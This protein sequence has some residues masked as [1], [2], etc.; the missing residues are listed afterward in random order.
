MQVRVTQPSI[1]VS[2]VSH[3]HGELVLQ[4]LHALSASVR[5]VQVSLRVWLT[6][7]LPEPALQ[8]AVQECDWPFELTQI[9]NPHPLGFGANHN[10]AYALSRAVEG[11]S[12]WF[13]VMNPDIFWPHDGTAFW[14]SL[15]I[16]WSSDVGLVCPAQTDQ[17]GRRQDF[18]RGLMT[19]WGMVWRVLRRLL[20]A[21]PSG[22][23]DSVDQADWINGACM[24]WRA[25]AFAAV[26]GFD[27]RYFMYCEDTDICLRLRLAGWRMREAEVTVVHDARRNTGRSWRHLSWHIRSMLRLWCSRAYWAYLLRFKAL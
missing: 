24:V 7:N 5:E 23:A 1:A 18:A 6:L 14:Q 11:G 20:G 8:S 17:Q 25:Q 10:Q 16:D 12:D 15:L 19:P 2:L 26:G 21:S 13:V 4:A 3:G 27:K 22:V 9:D